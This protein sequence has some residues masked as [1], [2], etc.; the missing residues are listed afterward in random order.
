MQEATPRSAGRQQ[1]RLRFKSEEPSDP[2]A[3]VNE[4]LG[5][6]EMSARE[7]TE[8]ELVWGSTWKRGSPQQPLE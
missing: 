7:V 1:Q 5:V 3:E 6:P 2:Q 4:T 8:A